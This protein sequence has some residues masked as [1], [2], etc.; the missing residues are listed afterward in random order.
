MRILLLSEFYPPLIGGEQRMAHNFACM[1]VQRGH[2]VAIATL[3]VGDLPE[4]EETDGM[5]VYRFQSTVQH[6]SWLYTDPMRPHMPPFPDLAATLALRR[7]VQKERPQVVHAFN[8]LFHSFLPLKKW[9]GARLVLSLGDHSLAC[10]RK[11]LTFRGRLD[12]ACSGP[13]FGKC[14]ACCWQYY[15]V[16]RGTATVGANWIMEKVARREVDLFLPVSDAVAE[17]NELKNSS[18]PYEVLFNFMNDPGDNPGIGY[19][20]L[21]AQLPSTPYV[22]FAGALS[23][24][25]GVDTLLEAYLSV[26]NAPPLVMIGTVPDGS[27]I[28]RTDFPSH[29]HVF[30]AWPHGAVMEAWRRCLMGIVPSRWSEPFG[31][32]ALEAMIMGRPVIASDIGGLP[33]FVLDD[34]TGVLVPPGDA[35]ALRAAIED[36]LA[37]PER[38]ESMGRSAQEWAL[39][40]T[41]GAFADRV[42]DIYAKLL[43]GTIH[44]NLDELTEH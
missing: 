32:V 42:E 10:S 21:L 4:Y 18:A 16:T 17:G 30:H 31:L 12:E 29:V 36:L 34:E 37:D 28:S 39:K 38:R 41:S 33:E 40:F 9:S 26:D 20:E 24:H 11:T 2:N 43:G 23:S 22:M 25:K 15:G 27:P 5:R 1:L 8:W 7:I 44:S 35:M 6:I 13:V 3:R 14:V 19:D